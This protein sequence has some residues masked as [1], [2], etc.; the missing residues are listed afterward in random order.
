MH[1]PHVLTQENGDGTFTVTF[2]KDGVTESVTTFSTFEEAWDAD[3]RLA[4]E[5]RHCNRS[6]RPHEP[7]VRVLK[8]PW[9]I[10]D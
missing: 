9:D 5:H 2:T 7:T 3:K 4:R 10:C 6:Y 1:L 8:I